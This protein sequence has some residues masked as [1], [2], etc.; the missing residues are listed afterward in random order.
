[1]RTL[2]RVIVDDVA[3]ANQA[4]TEGSLPKLIQSTMERLKP[5]AAYFFT[6]DGN[7]SCFMVFDMKDPSEI[8]AI[9]EPLFQGLNARVEFLPVMNAEDLQKGLQAAQSSQ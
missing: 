4:V 1:M 7:R 5:E 2:L 8:P 6:V 3:T 9:A